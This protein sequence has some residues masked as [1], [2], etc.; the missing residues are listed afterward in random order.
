M[1]PTIKFRIDSALLAEY[2]WTLKV[3]GQYIGFNVEVVTENYDIYVAEHGLGDIQ[4][5]HFFRNTYESGDKQFKAYFRTSPLHYTASNKPDYLSSCFYLLSYMQEYA[6]YYPDKYN[7]FPF[8][9]SV[10]HHYG[11]HR[12]N[13]VA[14]YFDQLY[15]SMP[16]LQAIISKKERP[17][18]FFLS[19]DID[20]VYGAF[21]DN[22][23][24][25]I[26]KMRIGT[27]MQLLFNH[28]IK[29]P[30][31]LLL[32]KIMDIEDEF[33][34]RSTFFWL[35]NQGKGTRNIHNADYNFKEHKI[36][37]VVNEITARGWANGLHK[38]AGKDTFENELKRLNTS[39][40]LI[41][42]NHYLLTELPTT[43]EALQNAGVQIDCTMG[44][45]ENIGFR[46]SYGLPIQPFNF[47]SKSPYAFIEVPLNVMDTTLKFYNGQNA[48]QAS[49]TIM[50]FLEN[51]KTNALISVLWHNNYFFDYA[52]TGWITTYKTILQFIRENKFEVIT[53]EQIAATYRLL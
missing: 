10:Q 33:D 41:N 2:T 23:A 8:E 43:F 20:S 18:A 22:Y 48:L 32:N 35:V 13:L 3:F 45:P 38:S 37:R 29:T 11:I 4:V 14:D 27:L 51:N 49:N 9:I 53:P 15:L 24:H 26:K 44:F 25:L 47:T 50:Q 34:V 52:D 30:D 42:R 39:G 21:G 36:Q 28:Y 1:H 16:K 17:A 7:R 5:S 19:H 46:N 12:Q 6:D 40:I 31:Y